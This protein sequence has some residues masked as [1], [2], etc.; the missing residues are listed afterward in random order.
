MNANRALKS[1][2]QVRAEFEARGET[3]VNWARAQGYSP[4]L[5]YEVLAGRSLCKRGQSHEIAVKLGLKRGVI[6][7]T[8]QTQPP[9]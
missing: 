3:F 7:A 9:D 6:P 2:D 5:V 8:S 1:A 4:N